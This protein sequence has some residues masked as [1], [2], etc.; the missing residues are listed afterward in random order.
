MLDIIVG[1]MLICAGI[2]TLKFYK[3][4][5]QAS[6]SW[7]KKLYLHMIRILG[8]GFVLIILGIVAIC[9]HLFF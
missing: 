2:I 1:L 6:F 4:L 5:S 7:E 3:P 9:N 8:L